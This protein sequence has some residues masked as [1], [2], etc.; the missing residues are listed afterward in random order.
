MIGCDTM[1]ITATTWDGRE[2]L[3]FRQ[4]QRAFKGIFGNFQ[5][6]LAFPVRI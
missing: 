3:V 1:D 6:G 2:V 4:G 5:K